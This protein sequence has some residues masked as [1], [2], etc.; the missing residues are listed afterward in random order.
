M[1]ME[2]NEFV[3]PQVD[4]NQKDRKKEKK[5]KKAKSSHKSGEKKHKKEKKSKVFQTHN[6]DNDHV[7]SKRCGRTPISI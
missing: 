3:D 4:E 7:E 6:L 5:I 2:N 1:T